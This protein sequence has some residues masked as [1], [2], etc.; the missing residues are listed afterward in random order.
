MSEGA[1]VSDEAR[2]GEAARRSARRAGTWRPSPR[3]ARCGAS[4]SARCPSASAAA[5]GSS[6]SCPPT[7]SP[8]RTRRSTRLGPGLRLRD[9]GSKNGTFLNRALVEDAAL[10]EGDVLHFADF[11]FRLGRSDVEEP[12]PVAAPDDDGPRPWR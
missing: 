2:G 4:G 3:A 11:E 7:P 10:G 6:W 12:A 9:L 5:T 1:R 8:R